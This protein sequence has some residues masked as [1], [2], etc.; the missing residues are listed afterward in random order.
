MCSGYKYQDLSVLLLL[1]DF[2]TIHRLNF[3]VYKTVVLSEDQLF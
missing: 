2:T 1:F 3:I